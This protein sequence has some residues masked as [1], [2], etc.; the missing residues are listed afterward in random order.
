MRGRI[1]SD[2]RC[3]ICDGAFQ[4]DERR[5]GLFCPEQPNQ[6]PDQ[7]TSEKTASLLKIRDLALDRGRR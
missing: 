4:Y 1:F 6:L 2:Q 5:R 3:P 7:D